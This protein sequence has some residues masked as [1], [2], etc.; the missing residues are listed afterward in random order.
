MKTRLVGV[1]WLSFSL[2]RHPPP[3]QACCRHP[4]RTSGSDGGVP[5]M[6]PIDDA[7]A[8]SLAHPAKNHRSRK[9]SNDSATSNGA[10][11]RRRAS[12]HASRFGGER[13]L[14]DCRSPSSQT[15]SLSVKPLR[16]RIAL[17]FDVMKSSSASSTRFRRSCCVRI[18]F[19]EFCEEF[20][21]EMNRLRMEH[22]ANLSSAERELERVRA[23]SARLSMR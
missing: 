10:R 23:L 15:G 19:E 8:L 16:A 6:T 5:G 3:V 7:R 18:S 12:T 1:F 22:R 21:R 14:I 17:P 11:A 9:T 4:R 13:L 20:T 2:A